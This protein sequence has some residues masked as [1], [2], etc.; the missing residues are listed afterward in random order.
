MI[1]QTRVAHVRLYCAHRSLEDLAKMQV[2]FT[3]SGAG[4]ESLR[5]SKY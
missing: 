5:F 2:R 1:K 4:P 3:M